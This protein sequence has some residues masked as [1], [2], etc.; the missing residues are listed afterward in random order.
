MLSGFHFEE[1]VFLQQSGADCGVKIILNADFK[2]QSGKYLHFWDLNA[3]AAAE[4]V[5]FKVMH[6]YFTV[7]STA[8]LH[9][10]DNHMC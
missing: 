3:N 5:P 4:R 2:F 9:S 7:F 1:N 8:G 6:W 10:S